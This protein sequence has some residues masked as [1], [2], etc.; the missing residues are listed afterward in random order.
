MRVIRARFSKLIYVWQRYFS[1]TSTSL[2][3]VSGIFQTES[4]IYDGAFLRKQS[5]VFS[6]KLLPKK[7]LSQIFGWGSNYAY[8]NILILINNKKQITTLQ[9]FRALQHKQLSVIGHSNTSTMMSYLSRRVLQKQM[10]HRRLFCNV[11]RGILRDFLLKLHSCLAK[12]KL[13]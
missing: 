10:F 2:V 8:A 6:C 4:N 9:N 5:A 12:K 1:K 11:A 7:A 3:Q 13:L